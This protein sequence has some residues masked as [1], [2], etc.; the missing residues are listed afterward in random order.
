MPMPTWRGGWLLS[1][2]AAEE[3]VEVA[4]QGARVGGC[5]VDVGRGAGAEHGHA[6]HVEPGGAGD[7]AAVVADVAGPVTHGDVEPGV[8]GPEACRPQHGGDLP[9]GE[10][11][12]QGRAGVDAGGCEPVRWREVVVDARAGGPLVGPVQ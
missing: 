7:D 4:S 5:A 8:V 11:Q 2:P 6:K 3:G 9:A 10:V 1:A 12:F